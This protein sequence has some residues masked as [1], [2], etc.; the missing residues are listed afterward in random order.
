MIRRRVGAS[1]EKCYWVCNEIPLRNSLHSGQEGERET[2]V[3]KHSFCTKGVK[4]QSSPP[5]K[6][7]SH[8]SIGEN[9]VMPLEDA[10]FEEKIWIFT[11]LHSQGGEGGGESKRKLK[12]FSHEI[13]GVT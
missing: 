1:F 3:P 2:Q 6:F 4:V 5:S 10:K 8:F 12:S 9:K 7:V 11:A 13:G